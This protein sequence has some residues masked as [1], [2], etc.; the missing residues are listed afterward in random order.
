LSS[1]TTSNVVVR[2]N[3]IFD[4]L[5][6]GTSNTLTRWALGIAITSGGGYNLFNNSVNLNTVSSTSL[7]SSALYV[8]SGV[9]SLDIR[10]NIFSNNLTQGT[11]YSIL[12]LNTANTQYN[13]LNYNDYYSAGTTL[14][15]FNT[16]A[17]PTFA[18]LQSTF[19][20]NANSKNVNPVFTSATDL[21][22]NT[23][24]NCSLDGAGTPIT[25]LT[26]DYDGDTRNATTPDIGADE[27]TGTYPTL[28][29]LSATAK[30]FSTSAQTTSLSYTA[31]N[32]PATYSITWAAT[33]T[34]TFAAVTNATIA[35]PI[36]VSIPANTAAGTYTGTI[37]AKNTAG[38]AGSASDFTVTV[39]PL[40]TVT[41]TASQ[42][43]CAGTSVTLAGAG[44]TSY[45]WTGNI[46]DNT[47][48]SANTTQT[49][50]VTGTDG[51]GCTN[52]ATSTVTVTPVTSISA[53]S[54][55]AQAVCVNGSFSALT[56]TA[57]GTGTLTYQWYSNTT[58][59]NTTGTSLGAS[60]QSASYTPSSA[61]AGTTYYY[62]VVTSTCGTA[63]SAVSG[64]M[65]V[66]AAPNAGTISGTQT[67]CSNGTTT[68]TTDGNTGGTWT[69][70]TLGVATVNAST[71]VITPVSAGT[72]II[73]YTVTGTGGCS[74][75]TAN[76]T[77][78]VTAAPN[79]GTISGTSTICQGA[80]AQLQTNGNA[81]G[82]WASS[83]SNV[84]T[85]SSSGV[86]TGLAAGTT[87]ITYTVSGTGG[88]SSAEAS[89]TATVNGTPTTPVV[90]VVNACGQST[91]SFTPAANATILWSNNATTSSTTTSINTTLTVVQT[92]NG[93][94]S[95]AGS[96][97]AVPLVI[98]SAP[99]ATAAQNFCVTDNATIASL[100][101]TNV[102]G[103]TYTWYDAA[104]A[105]NTVATSTQLP[106][107]TTTYYLSTTGS[108]GCTS[109]SRTAV[110]ATE[111]AQALATIS[112]TGTTVCAGGEIVFT[113]TPVNGG[114]SPTYQWYNGGVPISGA[115]GS[116]YSATGLVEGAVITVKMIPSGSCVTVCPN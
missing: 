28:S 83:N 14:A 27:F 29:S 53:Q 102:V 114:P 19:G 17:V 113:A 36:N 11:R 15:Y 44:A 24:S 65:V 63:T 100:A 116:T 81:G 16:T 5:N 6:G 90:S 94:P 8:A 75:A 3:Q 21:H 93:C 61:S 1:S 70:G 37:I 33:P 48:F 20:Q 97:S 96:G 87:S 47:A 25:S 31:A 34:N 51:N 80:T 109:T 106:T 85:V 67:I 39:N 101:Y 105:G 56:V 57:A 64:A 13:S 77:V 46:T 79:P 89:T 2:N 107:A 41:A 52:T 66:T 95:P 12:D 22:L 10:N 108:N 45:S 104:T 9:T 59:N 91:L 76:A 38:C 30:C 115:T 98:P 40:P 69:S 110:A 49:Y 7:N 74:N 50:T 111:A 82:T 32:S 43:V 42:T 54:T 68:F 103:N 55:A 26:T 71:G 72:S 86:I 62:C 60:A 92:V 4:I 58:A 84:A 73:T 23:S 99:T 88:C 112:I 35:S 78:T 18:N